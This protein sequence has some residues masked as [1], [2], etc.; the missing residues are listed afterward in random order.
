MRSVALG[1][2]KRVVSA[3]LGRE[4]GRKAGV[5]SSSS[6]SSFRREPE[7]SMGLEVVRVEEN[8]PARLKGWWGR[9]LGC[10]D[11]ESEEDEDE[12]L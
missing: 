1:S 7:L 4:Y 2:V 9:V 10:S 3:C 11:S 5:S 8:R 12:E 6:P